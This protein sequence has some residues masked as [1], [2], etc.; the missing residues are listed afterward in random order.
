M[1]GMTKGV[2]VTCPIVHEVHSSQ[3]LKVW[4]RESTNCCVVKKVR[5]CPDRFSPA[6]MAYASANMNH[7]STQDG[8]TLVTTAALSSHP[9]AISWIAQFTGRNCGRWI[10]PLRRRTT[11]FGSR[12]MQPLQRSRLP[13]RFQA[14]CNY[15]NRTNIVLRGTID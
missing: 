6:V 2:F 1:T 5:I 12:A 7:F 11:S 14:R 8:S 9:S 10:S 13:S 4:C 15:R 3:T